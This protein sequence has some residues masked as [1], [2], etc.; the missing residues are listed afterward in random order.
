MAG[1]CAV[2]LAACQPQDSL[3]SLHPPQSP[4]AAEIRVTAPAVTQGTC[5]HTETQPGLYETVTE[6]VVARPEQRDPTG[7][8]VNPAIIRS[9]THQRELRPRRD[10][11]FAV[12]CIAQDERFAATLQRALK[13]RGVYE[14]PIT[15]GAD[16]ATRS[17]LRRYQRSLGLDS[18]VLSL[19]AA[20][21]LGI[22]PDDFG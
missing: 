7:A 19:A 22:V 4:L 1:L 6:Q 8:V 15:G 14:G 9:E 11:W 17:A 2:L 21:M 12:P 3:M 20:R 13:A 10:I 5:W 16:P 18:D